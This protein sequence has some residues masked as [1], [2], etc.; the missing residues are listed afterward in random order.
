[1]AIPKVWSGRRDSQNCLTPS[2]V[3]AAI[4][5]YL[6]WWHFSFQE[7][8]PQK[9]EV[10]RD[11][12]WIV[13]RK[14][15]CMRVHQIFF[16]LQLSWLA[17]WEGCVGWNRSCVLLLTGISEAAF[18]GCNRCS[19]FRVL[20]SEGFCDWSLIL[21]VHRLEILNG[22]IFEFVFV[23][24]VMWDKEA[25]IGSLEPWLTCDGASHC[26]PASLGQALSCLLHATT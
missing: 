25:C 26:L 18:V 19:L 13:T 4:P 15:K 14:K 12:M 23:S 6:S 16:I 5:G 2:H 24:E 9:R 8:R 7:D 11:D 21:C 17:V 10:L 20:L 1:M 3:A 22:F